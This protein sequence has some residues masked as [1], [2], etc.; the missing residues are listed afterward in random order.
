MRR[1]SSAFVLFLLAALAAA[2]ACGT[3]SG[4]SGS[5]DFGASTDGGIASPDLSASAA[6]ADLGDASGGDVGPFGRIVLGRIY[7]Q[8]QWTLRS[9]NGGA[10]LETADSVGK[11][12]ASLKPT[13]VSGLVYFQ[14]S[15]ML[16]DRITADYNTVR[17]AVRQVSPHCR[18]DF[19][20]SLN[21]KQS[22]PFADG[23]ALTSKMA[24]IDAALHPDIWFFDFYDTEQKANPSI[25][26]AA[27]DYA[28]S[29]G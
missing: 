15:T 7:E 19:A 8:T 22:V 2:S 14:N 12:L 20:I 28:H 23:K 16:T 9:P 11:A 6:A 18:F 27:I 21:P 29:H 3:H 4:D 10:P 24:Q 5:N 25:V 13:Y 26:Q 1:L 17:S